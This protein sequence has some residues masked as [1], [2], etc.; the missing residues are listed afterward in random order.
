[1]SIVVLEW[2]NRS[3]IH[4]ERSTTSEDAAMS[5]ADR[6]KLLAR[7]WSKVNKDG[8]VSPIVGTP[9]WLW[10][11]WACSQGY[12]RFLVEG[13]SKR[14]HRCSYETCVGKIQDDL[15]L[16]H[17]CRVRHCVNPAHL[18]QVTNRE[19]I[20]RGMS[21]PTANSKKSH[22]LNGHILLGDNLII[23]K[24]G[25]RNC[26]ICQ[27]VHDRKFRDNKAS[28]EEAKLAKEAAYISLLNKRLDSAEKALR[29]YENCANY[30][31]DNGLG[32]FG[33]KPE[34]VAR[35]IIRDD[36]AIARAHFKEFPRE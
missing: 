35:P 28:R 3:G 14:A 20:F 17:L 22:C 25:H 27:L 15:V 34:S 29:F 6:A 32:N 11:G 33:G 16:D 1:M 19:N 5:D 4:P 21:G 30:E 18:E 8:P 2:A 36:G 9:C 23:S 31:N 7:F 24:K 26:R 10:T 13:K 12:G